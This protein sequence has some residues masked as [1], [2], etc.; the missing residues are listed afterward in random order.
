MNSQAQ[1]ANPSRK[2]IEHARQQTGKI[3]QEL[4]VAGAE[5]HLTNAALER[6]LPRGEKKGEVVRAL[7]QNVAIEEKVEDAA[8]DLKMVTQLLEQ[9][10]A[11]RVHLE[12]E[13]ATLS[14][15]R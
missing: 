6:N 2:P 14:R 1:A 13:L 11:Q 5:L 8:N 10:V 9:E 12:R 4:E 15:A 3:Q 7:V